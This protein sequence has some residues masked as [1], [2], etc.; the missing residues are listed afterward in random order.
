MALNFNIPSQ[1]KSF[2]TM[3]DFPA[4]GEA[5]TI[6]IAL[7]T[8]L[9]YIYDS[10]A[11]TSIG[12]AT[13]AEWGHISGDITSQ[14][15]LQTALDGK[16][17]NPTGD[18]TQYLN[19]AGTP[20]A[21]PTFASADKMVTVGRNSTGATL[22]KG[23]IVYISGSTGNRPNFVKAQ[24]NAESTSA[25]TFGVIEADI[26]N[27]SDGNCVTIGTINDLDTRS[28]APHPFT[29]DTLA[30]GDT[31]Y[32]SPTTAGYVTNVKPYAP[33]HLVYIG[34]VVRT[35]PTNG[36]IVYRIQNG[37]E[38][39]ELHDVAAQTPSNNDVLSF[40]TST[41]IWKPKSI[42]TLLGFTPVPTTRTISTTAPLS[43]GGDFS[44]NRTLSIATANG[45][46]TGALSSTDW[47]TFNGKQSA[48]VSGTNIKTINGNTILGSGDLTI[49]TGITIGTTAIT[50]G[51]I[52]RILFEG[53]GNVVQESVNLF[54]DNTNGRLGIGTIIP[55]VAV[56][57]VGAGKFSTTLEVTSSAGITLG[58]GA[59]SLSW[60]GTILELGNS[61][62]WTDV[63]LFA[64]GVQKFS[65]TSTLTTI[66]NT[67]IN[68]STATVQLAGVN[69][70]AYSGADVR[71]GSITAGF[72]SL[73]FYTSA[74]EKMRIAATTG[75]VLI[76]TTTD[77]GYKLDVNGTARVQGNT[78]IT[79]QLNFGNNNI[80][81][82]AAQWSAGLEMY[83]ISG[84]NENIKL[85]PS[86]QVH[87]SNNSLFTANTSA[88]LQVDSTTKGFLP[89]RMTT[90]QKNAIATP[91]AGLMVYDTTLNVIS[92][93]NGS[94][95]I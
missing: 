84:G 85:S 88:I 68:L 42:P 12:D 55:T 65:Q 80:W 53:T 93:Y 44:A 23:T 33:S 31:I 45:T 58:G 8:K 52:G 90:T 11:Y 59:K 24:A 57:V 75:N 21:F 69:A 82:G 30:D 25:G 83:A 34:K 13:S 81:V 17:N 49:S 92:Y 41:Q 76:S 15:D 3:G 91:A 18:T 32:L 50:S 66:S 46:T 86:Q 61:A 39:D 56:D 94:M 28:S 36:T 64:S 9:L 19:G 74:T 16:F 37:Y 40:E 79:G 38:L 78:R 43:G 7:D 87:I 26:P 1:V 70:L 72:T 47:N 89:P 6:Y 73:S 60:T 63:R 67:T 51:T 62:T 71:I 29:S 22:Y 4:T 20:T 95:W 35:S 10:G 27:N 77:A 14:T 2:P 5:K 48:L 54:W